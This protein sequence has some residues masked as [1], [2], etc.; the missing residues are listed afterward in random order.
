[1]SEYLLSFFLIL[2]FLSPVF[3]QS[4]EGK[5]ITAENKNLEFVTIKL[6]HDTTVLQY[7]SSDQNGNFAFNNLKEKSTYRLPT[8]R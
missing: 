4:V 7:S 3:A 8:H 5:I 6:I 2:Q 1:M